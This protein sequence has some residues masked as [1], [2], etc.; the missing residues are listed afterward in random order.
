MSTLAN[1]RVQ[2]NGGAGYEADQSEG[3]SGSYDDTNNNDN[4]FSHATDDESAGYRSGASA[5]S[6]GTGNTGGKTQGT[7]GEVQKLAQKQTRIV[8]FWRLLVVS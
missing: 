2:K 8:R 1:K 4:D 5:F 6:S 7:D 3:I